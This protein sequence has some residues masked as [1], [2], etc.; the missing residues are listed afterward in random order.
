MLAATAVAQAAPKA[1]IFPFELIDVSIEGA[2]P[3]RADEAQRLVLVTEE[4]RQLA[5]RNCAMRCSTLAGSHPRSRGPHR[6]TSAMDAR[7]ILRAGSAQRSPQR[8]RAEVSNSILNIH[9]YVRDVGSGKLTKVHQADIRGNTDESWLRGI[10]LAGCE[11]PAAG[12]E[13]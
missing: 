7:S 11:P 2:L 10:S 4:L 9:I 13:Y 1:A 5:S 12:R 8:D 3:A 6:F